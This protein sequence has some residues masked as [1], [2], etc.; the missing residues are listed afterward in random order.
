[1]LTRTKAQ[2]IKHAN[3]LA[4]EARAY[5]QRSRYYLTPQ[6]EATDGSERRAIAFARI[7][8]DRAQSYVEAVEEIVEI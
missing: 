2:R 6:G 3:G 5:F 4:V 1:M 7:A 8:R